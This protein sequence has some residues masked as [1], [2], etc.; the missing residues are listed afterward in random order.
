[1]KNLFLNLFGLENFEY[2][3]EEKQNGSLESDPLDR[4]D[5]IDSRIRFESNSM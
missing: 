4:I 3:K 2:Y 1:M 5:W